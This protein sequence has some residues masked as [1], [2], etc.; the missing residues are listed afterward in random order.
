[1]REGME[2]VFRIVAFFAFMM[3][4]VPVIL[5]M[6]LQ[7]NILFMCMWNKA[8]RQYHSIGQGKPE[9]YKKTFY[10][11]LPEDKIIPRL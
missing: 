1:M 2:N 5:S 10:Q 7:N 6:V 9:Q 4:V 8:V 11:N 3:V